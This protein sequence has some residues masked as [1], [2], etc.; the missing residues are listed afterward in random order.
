MTNPRKVNK[1]LMNYKK[2]ERN[3][4]SHPKIERL[5]YMITIN[6]SAFNRLDTPQ[7][8]NLSLIPGFISILSLSMA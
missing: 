8:R 2:Q 7:I 5:F 4:P 6:I 3:Y 1:L